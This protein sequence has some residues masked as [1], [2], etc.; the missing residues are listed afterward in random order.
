MAR[1]RARSRAL[2]RGLTLIELTIALA[3]AALAVVMG[4]IAID[5]GQS[6]NAAS[7]E[8][9]GAVKYAYDRSIMQRQIHRLAIDLDDNRYWLEYT[10][11]AFGLAERRLT[12]RKGARIDGET[13]PNTD[14]LPFIFDEDDDDEVKRALLGGRASRFTALGNDGEDA[15]EP[16]R[17]KLP[18][19]VDVT[20]I[21]TGH[22][23]EPFDAGMTYLHFF[24]GGW[25]EPALIEL[26]DGDE[27]LTLEVSP[28]TGR[29]RTRP[30]KMKDPD[31]EE[32]SGA[33]EGD[34]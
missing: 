8:L 13:T 15:K 3:I 20:R 5:S 34:E 24:Y 29:V 18:G 11:E 9:T 31:V 21:W 14:D 4:V 26:S 22:Q 23:E 1:R 19:S 17:R 28:L 33:E 12:G 16:P 32:H 6:L 7:V 27:F 10:D 25:T 30:G 2:R